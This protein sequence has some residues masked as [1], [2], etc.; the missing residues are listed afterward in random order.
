MMMSGSEILAE[1]RK[2]EELK[3]QQDRRCA[4][5]FADEA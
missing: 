2:V 4:G 5:S 3:S 1:T